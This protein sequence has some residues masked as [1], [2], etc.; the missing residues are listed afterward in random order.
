MA[1]NFSV[2]K[3]DEQGKKCV[4]L[5]SDLEEGANCVVISLNV[6][7]SNKSHIVRLGIYP[8]DEIY[9]IKKMGSIL[10]V[11]YGGMSCVLCE[12]LASYI[13]VMVPTT[14]KS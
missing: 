2:S 11:S 4:V 1:K 10:F 3:S 9:I 7:D 14:L 6:Y 13:E 5:L 12:E 8:G